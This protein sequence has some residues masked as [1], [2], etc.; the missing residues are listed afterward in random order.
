MNVPEKYREYD[1]LLKSKLD[2]YRYVHSINVSETS[3]E[4]ARKY[5][6]DEK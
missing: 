1:E 3:A 5:G 4:L 6:A 2:E